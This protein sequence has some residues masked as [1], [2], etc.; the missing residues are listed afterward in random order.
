MS[1]KASKSLRSSRVG[2][3]PSLLLAGAT[4]GVHF[5]HSSHYIRRIRIAANSDLLEPLEAAG[6]KIEDDKV[7]GPDTKVVEIPISLGS[8]IKALKDV[9]IRE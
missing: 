1:T 3:C 4:P 5:P 2:P 9:G 7:A 6:Y 8:K